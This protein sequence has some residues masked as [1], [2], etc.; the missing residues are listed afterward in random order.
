MAEWTYLEFAGVL[1]MVGHEGITASPGLQLKI[2]RLVRDLLLQSLPGLA[3]Q[4]NLLD[5][6]NGTV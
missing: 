2:P 5:P 1:E 4:R 3:H 6:A